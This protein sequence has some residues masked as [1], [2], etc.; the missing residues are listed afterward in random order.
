LGSISAPLVFELSSK[1]SEGSFDVFMIVLAGCMLFIG[2]FAK[3]FLIRETKGVTLKADVFS[4]DEEAIKTSTAS[5]DYGTVARK[6]PG[7]V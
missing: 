4:D 6:G 7:K 5:V 3:V 2:C 1:Y